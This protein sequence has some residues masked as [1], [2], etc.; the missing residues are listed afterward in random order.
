MAT[1]NVWWWI[2]WNCPVTGRPDR[3]PG[4]FRGDTSADA[5]RAAAI[6]TGY[7]IARLSARRPTPL[8]E[9]SRG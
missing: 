2:D 5:I 4:S 8:Y 3:I 6:K 9:V 1:K 7:D